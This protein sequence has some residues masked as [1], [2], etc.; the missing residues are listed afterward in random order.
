MTVS[1]R[2]RRAGAATLVSLQALSLGVP[3]A[4]AQ[5]APGAVAQQVTQVVGQVHPQLGGELDLLRRQIDA[6]V[7]DVGAVETNL[8]PVLESAGKAVHTVESYPQQLDA[9][10]SKYGIPQNPSLG[11]EVEGVGRFVK[12]KL[13]LPPEQTSKFGRLV[14]QSP[15]FEQ[16]KTPFQP[17]NIM[18]A[19]GATAGFNLIAQMRSDEGFD[20]GKA[21]AFL[22]QGNFWGGLIGSGV[23][24]GLMASVA[25]FLFP[26]AAGL[27][28]VLAPMFA[29][30]FG[31]LVGWE[32]GSG[33]ASG[34][35]LAES[36]GR[37]DPAKLLGHAAGSTVGLLVG[38]NVGAALGGVLGSVAGPLGAIA[39]AVVLGNIGA[40]LGEAAKTLLTGDASQFDEAV[41]DA[42]S[43]L[44]KI[45]KAGQ[46]LADLVPA[47]LPAASLAQ[48]G[49]PGR[50][51][52]EYDRNYTELRDALAAGDRATA[53]Y[54]IQYLQRL[55]TRY[56]QSIG[57]QLQKLGR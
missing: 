33:L 37:L 20:L 15:L 14:T 4:A 53:F 42:G 19:V 8:K 36:M 23:G 13:G 3:V 2:M 56:S 38:A 35:P 5:T 55:Q 50:L 10:K 11:Q 22:G 34:E 25:T 12:D 47:E 48:E 1:R 49:L 16:F 44:D 46:K 41:Q 9:F 7:K 45:Q 21:L 27:V 28:P 6:L 24:Y 43:V 32:L 30:M 31:S 51:K 17:A 18:L 29:G 39:G 54:K 52:A 57:D 40:N 26:P